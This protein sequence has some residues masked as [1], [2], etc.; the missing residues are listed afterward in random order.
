[1]STTGIFFYAQPNFQGNQVAN[2]VLNPGQTYQLPN[3]STN[4]RSLSV[5]PGYSITIF[6]QPN[7]QGQMQIFTGNVPNYTGPTMKSYVA[8]GPSTSTSAVQIVQPVSTPVYAANQPTPA[9]TPVY[10]AN[11][12]TPVNTNYPQYIDVN[13]HPIASSG[14]INSSQLPRYDQVAGSNTW[15]WII[16][17]IIIILI[18]LFVLSRRY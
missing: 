6:S 14:V 5:S 3:V 12:P 4:F 2:L 1:M 15:I 13:G 9:N 17:L 10:A 8:K 11:Q 16:I 7:Y 18:I